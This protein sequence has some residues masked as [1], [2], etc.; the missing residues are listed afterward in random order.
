[1]RPAPVRGDP[2]GR[3]TRLAA[4]LVLL[5]GVAPA[6]RCEE[7]ELFI[8]WGIQGRW[9]GQIEIRQGGFLSIEPYSFE[10]QY[11]DA[12]LGGDAAR[13]SWR[14]GVAMQLD[15]LH[16]NASVTAKTVFRLTFANQ[17]KELHP[18]DFR[19]D[20]DRTVPLRGKERFLVLGLG[21]PLRRPKL[22][23]A[24]PLP[25]LY[26]GPTPQNAI[27]LPRGA[28]EGSQPAVVLHLEQPRPGPLRARRCSVGDG[29]LYVEVYSG[30]GPIDGVCQVECAGEAVARVTVSGSIWLSLVPRIGVMHVSVRHPGADAPDAA[31]ELTVPTTLVEARGRRVYLNGEPFLVKGTL[32]RNLNAADAAYLKSL[33]AN[34]V[35][36]R[37][38]D[39]LGRYGFMGIIMTGRDPAK[40]CTKA[41]TSA[42]FQQ[43]LAKSMRG[44]EARCAAA[45]KNP[46][47]LILQHANEQV[48]GADPWAGRVGRCSFDRLDHV[49]AV[50]HNIVRA[51]DPM[52][53]QGYSNCAWG[54]RA[55]DSLDVYL[56][57]TYLSKDRNWPPLEDFI[58]YQGCGARP[59]V[60]TEFGANVYMPQA[61]LRGPNTPVLEKIHAWNYPNRWRRYLDAGACGGTN[62]CFYDYDY[63]KVN[64]NGW[65]KGFTNFGVMTFDRKPKLACWELWH[66]WRDFEVEPSPKRSEGLRIRYVRE[67]WAR[68]CKLS[69][70]GQGRQWS[71]TL[72]DFAPGSTRRVAA[73][74]SM[75]DRSRWHMAYVTHRGVPM[76]A[77]GAWPAS[78][79]QDDF[80]ARLK[81][82]KTFRFLRELLDAKVVPVDGGPEVATLKELER[83]DGV[84]ALA[85]VKPNGTAYV[86]AFTRKCKGWLMAGVSLDVAFKG[87]VEAVDDMTGQPTGE[88]VQ[89][90]VLPEGTR[91]MG[92]TVPRI[93]AAYTRRSHKPVH[94]PVIRITRE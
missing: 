94:M 28:G 17:T 70:E 27:A 89:T 30:L 14:S 74:E 44:Y 88:R 51:L 60:H 79:E 35:R 92:L 33:C 24:V 41:K 65:D 57:N 75:M 12:W 77:C 15:G 26:L 21:H 39:Y 81:T 7:L 46:R 67:Y 72:T 63:S 18:S 43:Y 59:Y 9:D 71:R 49:L 62:Y 93:P 76:V 19:A 47:T 55:P 4:C 23:A 48:T 85:L 45:V 83:P 68:E 50:R 31:E 42:E 82:R 87:R 38:L 10:P 37:S 61:H 34:T 56:H 58:A 3:A 90:Q 36:S 53:L 66:L 40:F 6:C 91:I 2:Q 22:P 1:M 84:V 73:P 29:R 25:A 86:S 64:V 69:I 80:I 13:A 5:L 11:G 20:E 16:A 54:Y 32:P 8:L 52:T 78:A